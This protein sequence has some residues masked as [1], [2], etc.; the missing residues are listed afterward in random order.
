MNVWRRAQLAGL[1]IGPAD[2]SCAAQVACPAALTY[3]VHITVITHCL[4]ERQSS[5]ARPTSLFLSPGAHMPTLPLRFS[6][7]ASSQLFRQILAATG[8]SGL[9]A[10]RDLADLLLALLGPL[11]TPITKPCA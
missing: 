8:S 4:R 1:L 7:S 10:A 11:P 9:T 2:A 3:L 6:F 5:E